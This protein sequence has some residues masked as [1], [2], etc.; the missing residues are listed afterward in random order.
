MD[1]NEVFV[2]FFKSI[3]PTLAAL[4]AFV[5]AWRS[6][7]A[8]I[9]NQT[10]LTDNTRMTSD[11]ARDTAV[12]L[13]HVNSEK[14]ADTKNIEFLQREIQI[15]R[16]QLASKERAAALLAQS[17]AIRP[18]RATDDVPAVALTGSPQK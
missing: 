16:E 9:N 3:A 5:M 7:T 14:M 6:K 4:A 8:I 17:V 10:A 18:H 2:E 15:L 1:G 11:A 13:G 12:I